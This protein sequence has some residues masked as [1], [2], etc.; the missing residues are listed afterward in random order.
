MLLLVACCCCYSLPFALPRLS[1]LCD[2]TPAF[3][4]A[5]LLNLTQSWT[6]PGA[7]QQIVALW[8]AKLELERR[9]LPL[10]SSPIDYEIHNLDWP[11]PIFPFS[12]LSSPSYLLLSVSPLPLRHPFLRHHRPHRELHIKPIAH[13]PFFSSFS[14]SPCTHHF[15]LWR[16]DFH[17]N[18]ALPTVTSTLF[19]SLV[20]VFRCILVQPDSLSSFFSQIFSPYDMR[21]FEWLGVVSC[22]A[23]PYITMQTA[24]LESVCACCGSV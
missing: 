8:K 24:V 2:A 17:L 3:A 20:V 22:P 15:S 5:L 13:F 4:F 7:A 19:C 16:S 11:P 23:L 21:Y 14:F 12:S 1:W 18:F 6:C 9:Y 10:P